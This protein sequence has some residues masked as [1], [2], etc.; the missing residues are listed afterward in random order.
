MTAKLAVKL[1]SAVVNVSLAGIYATQDHDVSIAA[2][3]ATT[4]VVAILG[5]M[6]LI[7]R[8]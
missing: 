6:I 7:A 1:V 3:F 4:F 5:W 8:K 2:I